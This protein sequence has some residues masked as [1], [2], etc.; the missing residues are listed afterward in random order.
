MNHYKSEEKLSRALSY[1]LRH[2]PPACIS[3][4]G[5]VPL[6]TILA[7]PNFSIY[8][9]SDIRACVANNTKQRFF[10][11]DSTRRIR[12]NQGHTINV[13][14]LNLEP[15]YPSVDEEVVHGTYNE[16]W[17]HIEK[18]GL[19][20]MKRQHIHMALKKEGTR[21]ISGMR[22]DCTCFIYIDTEKAIADGYKFYK[23]ANGVILCYGNEYGI[24][25]A[26]YFKSTKFFKK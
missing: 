9:E 14:D 11:C 17:P 19:S 24:L 7:L 4:D 21:T 5:F 10:I 8:T 25:P 6:D 26:K 16:V 3:S 12:A 23:S 1:I 18:H 2:K 22:L 13:P 20:R 15:Y